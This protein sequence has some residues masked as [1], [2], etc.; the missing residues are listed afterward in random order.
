MKLT[1]MDFNGELIES[2]MIMVPLNISNVGILQPIT[3]YKCISYDFPI[4]GK[5]A[6]AISDT[7][8]KSY[9]MCDINGQNLHIAVEFSA[10]E[11]NEIKKILNKI[12]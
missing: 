10:K 11:K 1:L 2:Q 9:L 4:I 8:N 7:F 3:D 12:G 5:S 6:I